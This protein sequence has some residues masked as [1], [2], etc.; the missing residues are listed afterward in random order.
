MESHETFQSLLLLTL[1]A[2]AVPLLVRQMGRVVRLPIIVGE[3]VADII[4]GRSGLDLIHETATPSSSPTSVSSFSCFS[5][6][7]N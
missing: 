6:A 5:P 3:I 2:L 1:L 7:W 4:V